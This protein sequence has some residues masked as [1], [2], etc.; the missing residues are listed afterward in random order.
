MLLPYLYSLRHIVIPP[1]QIREHECVA[2]GVEGLH[3]GLSVNDLAR[4][5]FVAERFR[6]PKRCEKDDCG[7]VRTAPF[8][9]QSLLFVVGQCRYW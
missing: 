9:Y 3:D 1:S 4:R 7:F 2:V 6:R 8:S 5:G